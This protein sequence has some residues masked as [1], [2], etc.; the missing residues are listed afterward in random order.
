LGEQE[1]LFVANGWGGATSQPDLGSSCDFNPCDGYANYGISVDEDDDEIYA[2][3]YCWGSCSLCGDL[4][5]AC[6]SDLD[7]DQLIGV[8]DLLLLLV[9]FGCLSNCEWD[10]NEDGKVDIED[11]LT[12]LSSYGDSCP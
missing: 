4:S 2:P 1:Y 8:D 10:P 9:E 6:P 11:L 5:P 3:L 7:G 12:M